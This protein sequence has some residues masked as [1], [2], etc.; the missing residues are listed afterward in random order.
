MA[1]LISSK[2]G[3]NAVVNGKAKTSVDLKP[4]SKAT[5]KGIELQIGANEGQT[6]SFTLDDMSAD[7]LGVGVGKVDLSKQETA[8]TATT[9]IDAAIKKISKA[10]VRWVPFRTDLSTQSTTLTQLLEYA[11]S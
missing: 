11:D 9:T 1:E 2:T 6:M 8:K 5:G 10:E 4:S 3:I 7:A